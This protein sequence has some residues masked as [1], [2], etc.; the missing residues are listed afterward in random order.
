MWKKGVM[1][2]A[3]GMKYSPL[4]LSVTSNTLARVWYVADRVLARLCGSSR[5]IP[6]HLIEGAVEVGKGEII[7]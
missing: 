3:P 4:V 7:S 5:L 2:Q 1:R 6:Y